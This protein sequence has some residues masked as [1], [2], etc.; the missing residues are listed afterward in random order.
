MTV[1]YYTF[2]SGL[3]IA[4]VILVSVWTLIF[5][6]LAVVMLLIFLAVKRTIDKFNRLL[7][8]TERAAEEVQ[9][10]LKMAM[11][12]VAGLMSKN[13]FDALKKIASLAHSKSSTKKR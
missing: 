5:I 2:M 6:I 13:A 7:D 8:Q 9:L 11:A 4:L 3:E 10:P 1:C 12:G